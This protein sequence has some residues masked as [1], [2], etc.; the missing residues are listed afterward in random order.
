M[1]VKQSCDLKMHMIKNIKKKLPSSPHHKNHF[2]YTARAIVV[3][4][5]NYR[6][7]DLSPQLSVV[8]NLNMAKCCVLMN[9]Y[10]VST[11]S[12]SCPN[13]CKIITNSLPEQFNSSIG[14]AFV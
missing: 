13:V 6:N 12:T 10:Y 2:E 8:F 14:N 11:K 3:Y 1:W 4:A 7:F 5:C 9:D